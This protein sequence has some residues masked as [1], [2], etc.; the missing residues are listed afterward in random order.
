MAPPP[1]VSV[2]FP[3]PIFISLMRVR[4]LWLRLA[5]WGPL[6]FLLVRE[7][8]LARRYRLQCNIDDSLEGFAGNG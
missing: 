7:A 1:I 5:A 3:S 6:S 4:P 2:A 8:I